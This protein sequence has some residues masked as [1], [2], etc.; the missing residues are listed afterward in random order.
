MDNLTL[1]KCPR[2]FGRLILE[3]QFLAKKRYAQL[4]AEITIHDPQFDRIMDERFSTDINSIMMQQF[5]RW[6][7]YQSPFQWKHYIF[8]RS[9]TYAYYYTTM[10]MQNM[11]AH[12]RGSYSQQQY[13]AKFDPSNIKNTLHELAQAMHQYAEHISARQQSAVSFAK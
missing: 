8:A 10:M 7:T 4:L 13:D 1:S 11:I 5:N 9:S 2:S 3:L 12:C 6:K